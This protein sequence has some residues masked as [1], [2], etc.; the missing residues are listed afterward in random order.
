MAQLT[1]LFD[2]EENW[3]IR[4]RDIKKVFLRGELIVEGGNWLG[5]EGLCS[6]VKRG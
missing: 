4:A 2:P 1:L 5:R 3:T 6:Y